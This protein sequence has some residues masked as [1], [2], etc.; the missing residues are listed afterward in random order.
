[1]VVGKKVLVGF[2]GF[3]VSFGSGICPKWASWHF[4]SHTVSLYFVARGQ[5]CPGTSTAAE[6]PRSQ[7]VSKGR[8]ESGCWGWGEHLQTGRQGGIEDESFCLGS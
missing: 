8:K 5:V 6:G 1:M 2:F 4:Q 3:F 7:P